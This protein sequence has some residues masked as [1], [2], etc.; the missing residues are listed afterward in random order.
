MP[1]ARAAA[2][3][4]SVRVSI[5]WGLVYAYMYF[6]HVSPGATAAARWNFPNGKTAVWSPGHAYMTHPYYWAYQPL[7]G[8]GRYR[9]T[10]LV[11]GRVAGVHDF[12]VSGQP[13]TS[14]TP[15]TA[16]QDGLGQGANGRGHGY[17]HGH[18]Y[19]KGRNKGHGHG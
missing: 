4:A 10:A 15:P 7:A 1:G 5:R 18:G 14:P 19:G 6:Q 11:N 3:T 13:P 12:T 17:G 16:N 8:P 9:V 2:A